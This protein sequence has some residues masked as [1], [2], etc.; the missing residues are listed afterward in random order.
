MNHSLRLA[1]VVL[2]AAVSKLF[3]ETHYVSLASPNPTPPYASWDTAATNI[4]DAVDAAVAGDEIV[5]TNGIYATGSRVDPDSVPNRVMVGKPLLVRS[6]NGAQLTTIQGYRGPIATNYADGIR[7]VYLTNGASLTGFTLTNGAANGTGGGLNSQWGAAPAV[8]NCVIVGNAAAGSGGGVAHATLYNCN[9]NGNS[10]ATNGSAGGGAFD[11]SLYNC[12]LSSNWAGSGGAAYAATLN[13][14]IVSRN[15]AIGQ[16]G[17]VSECILTNCLL[18]G[19]SVTND[20]GGAWGGWLVNCTVVGNSAATGGG[21]AGTDSF[22]IHDGCYLLNSIIYYNTALLEGT[23]C[24]GCTQYDCCTPDS[25]GGGNVTYGTGITNEPLLLNLASG[26]YR[27]QSSSPFINAGNNSYVNSI[28][29][30]DGNPRIKSGTVDI[31]SYEFQNP[32]SQISYAWL[33]QYALPISSSTDSADPDGDGMNNWQEW[34]AGTDPTN[35]LSVL[36]MLAP[37]SRVP[38]I[39]VQWQSANGVTYFLQRSTNLNSPF[40]TLATDLFGYPGVFRYDDLSATGPGPYF[41]RVGIQR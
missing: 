22:H 16:G 40:T 4:Q 14:C 28:F 31:G 24:S 30:L 13:N 33:Q 27:L 7:C 19:N 6:V 20:G 34:I 37:T 10:A 32:V 26:N 39:T 5:V 17:G 35:A 1:I 29:D 9:I 11:C 3:G 21:G 36:R 15:W 8:S 25:N 18:M 41:Y 2:L 23:N 12:T 38:G